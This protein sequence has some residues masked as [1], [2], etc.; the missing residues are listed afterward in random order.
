MRVTVVLAARFKATPSP[1]L[2][3]AT[4]TVPMHPSSD[5]APQLEAGADNYGSVTR[6][7]VT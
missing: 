3:V 4:P 2:D 7:P 6:H 5:S 1:D